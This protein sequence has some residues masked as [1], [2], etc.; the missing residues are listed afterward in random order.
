[1]E[2]QNII[3][4][5]DKKNGITLIPLRDSSVVKSR[6]LS[7]DGCIFLDS[8]GSDIILHFDDNNKLSEIELIGFDV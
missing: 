1:M 8:M 4:S 3:I 5:K 7:D 2:N 6:S